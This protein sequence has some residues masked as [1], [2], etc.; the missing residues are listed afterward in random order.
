M[1]IPV[2]KIL[3]RIFGPVYENDFGWRIRRNKELYEL[4]DE[5]D[6]VKYINIKILQCASHM[7]WMD[8]TRIPKM[9][10]IGNFIDEDLWEDH[11]KAG[12][13]CG[14]IPCCWWIKEDGG[15]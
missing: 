11:G 13:T 8:N 6:I 4:L 5:P 12:K 15:A 10:W 1:H 7:V 3:S 9:H 14:G 2:G